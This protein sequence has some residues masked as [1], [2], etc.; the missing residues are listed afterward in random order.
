MAHLQ[1]ASGNMGHSSG[2]THE[3]QGPNLAKYQG[4]LSTALSEELSLC[5]KQGATF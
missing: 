3:H 1:S 5:F 4:D 2:D